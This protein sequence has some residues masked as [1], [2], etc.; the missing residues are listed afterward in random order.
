MFSPDTFR[1]VL[2]PVLAD[3]TSRLRAINPDLL[4]FLHSDGNLYSVLPDLIEI[5][6]QG[7][8]PIQP[9]CMDM[10]QVKREFGDRLTLIGGIS[11]QTELPSKTPEELKAIVRER[12]DSL[13]SDGGFM[14]TSSNTLLPDAP[15]ENI[16][17][18][19]REAARDF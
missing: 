7:V 4:L 11:V 14:V 15:P 16:L 1:R 2:K 5:G 19:Y 9:E 6:F 3:I 18:A 13:G 10:A 12:V 8:H 17:A